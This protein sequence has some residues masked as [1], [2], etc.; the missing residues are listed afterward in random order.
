M[1]ILQVD[2]VDAAAA[3]SYGDYMTDSLTLVIMLMVGVALAGAVVQM[4]LK[5]VMRRYAEMKAPRGLTGRAIAEQMLNSNGI[6]NVRIARVRGYLTDHFDPRTMTVYLSDEVYDR[7][8]VTAVAVATH[9]CGHAVQ[10]VSGYRPI[11]LRMRLV[12][13]IN[14]SSRFAGPV[15]LAGIAMM[16]F[17]QSAMLCWIGVAMIALSALF[18]LVTLPVEYNASRRAVGW[19][20]AGGM[21]TPTELSA[22]N[23]ALNWAAKTYL[24]AA[25]SAL[26]TLLYHIVMIKNRRS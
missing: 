23:E 15:I 12:P 10:Y 17:T 25:V 6:Y 21:F 14:F 1:T 19:L 24:V 4:R 7:D 22:A 11:Y 16:S 9:E 26:V 3:L 5:A 8:S 20:K 18:A 13:I 2:I